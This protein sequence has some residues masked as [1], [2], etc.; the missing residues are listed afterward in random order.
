[1]DGPSGCNAKWNKSEKDQYYMVLL[2]CGI[3][4]TNKQTNKQRNRVTDT[5]NELV[6][7]S[8]VGGMKWQNSGRLLRD[9][10]T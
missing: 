10:N 2:I 3:S 7:A 6:V 5:E 9:T 4:K 8:G 1:M